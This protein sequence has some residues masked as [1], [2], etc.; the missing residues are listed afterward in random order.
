MQIQKF[1]E[2]QL[3]N[4]VQKKFKH[5][6]IGKKF[7]P[8]LVAEMSGNHNGDLK[9]AKKIILEAKKNGADAIKLQTFKPEGMTINSKKKEFVVK[10]KLKKWNNKSLYDLYKKSYLPWNFQEK[11]FKYAK[12]QGILIFS[13]VFDLESL[14]FLEKIKNPIYKISSFEITDLNLIKNVAKK[15]KPIILSTGS[16]FDYEIKNAIKVIKKYS[17]ND[18]ILLKCT[19][20]YPAEPDDINLKSII[21]FRK[22]Y[23]CDIG[24]SDHTIGSEFAIASIALGCV[25]IEKHFTINSENTIDS[26]FSANQK[27]LNN[28]SK[29]IKNIYDGLGTGKIELSKKEIIKRKSKRSLFFARDL[30]RNQILSPGDIISRRPV[31]GISSDKYFEIINKKI[32][33]KVKKFEPIKY[34]CF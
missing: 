16:A 3:I 34:N 7:K 21:T 19:S 25:L 15:N 32:K 10:S 9:R 26:A 14:E 8:F 17:R 18:F 31:V 4:M 27:V 13:S 5:Y 29:G 23:G 28:I 6:K 33:K 20:I 1:L 24:Y 11:L 2:I 22:K 12:D 30:N